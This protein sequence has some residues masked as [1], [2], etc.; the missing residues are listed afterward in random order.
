MIEKNVRL[1]EYDDISKGLNHYY[2]YTIFIEEFS[3]II[4]QSKVKWSLECN[5][6]L[7]IIHQK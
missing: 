4:W 5:G 2:A 7:N 6:K 3:K 1:N